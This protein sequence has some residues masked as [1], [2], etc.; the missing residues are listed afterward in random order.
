MS[1]IAT[2]VI[3]REHPALPGHFPGRPI[4]PGVVALTEV[5][6]AVQ[7]VYGPGLRFTGVAAA[8]FHAPL[9]PGHGFAIAFT[10]VDETTLGFRMTAGSALIASGKLRCSKTPA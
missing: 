10:R 2:G 1:G 5:W 3:S 8:K 9:A 4:V 7:R 6:R